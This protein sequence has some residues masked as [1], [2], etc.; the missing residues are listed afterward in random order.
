MLY[1]GELED[2]GPQYVLQPTARP[3]WFNAMLDDQIYRTNNAQQSPTNKATSDV[4]VLA[5]QLSAESETLGFLDDIDA[6]ARAGFRY[7]DFTYG[8]I[9]GTDRSVPPGQ[10]V[11]NLDFMTYTPYAELLYQKDRWLGSTGVS[12]SAFTQDIP[13]HSGTFYQEWVPYWALGYQW[14]L[15]DVQTLLLQYNGDYRFTNT[16]PL[17]TPQAADVNDKTDQSL[18]VV[19]SHILGNHWVLQPSYRLMWSGYSNSV[20]SGRN[21]IYN[22]FSMVV[23]YYFDN[24]ISLR[25]FTSYEFRNSSGTGTNFNY[26]NWNIGAGINAGYSF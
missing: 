11:K 25:A 24:G 6:K 12:Y 10:P 4:D 16:N 1:E 7:N 17:G 8:L 15:S 3:K 2:I 21:D 22:T 9:S 14:N 5:L 18:S 23:A 13:S 20:P 19:Y 26:Q